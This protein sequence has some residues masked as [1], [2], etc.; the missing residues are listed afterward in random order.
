LKAMTVFDHKDEPHDEELVQRL[1]KMALEIRKDVLLM[2]T[3]AGSGHPGGSLSAAEMIACLYFHHLRYDPENPQWEDRDRFVLSKGHVCP[4]LYSALSRAGFFPREALWTLRKIGSILQ[5]HP[6]MKKTPG[7][8]ASTGSLGQGLSIGVGMALAGRIDRKSYRVYV[9]LGDGELDEGQVWEA[10]MSAAHYRLDNLLAII[11]YNGLQLDGPVNQIM[12][13]EPIVEKWKAFGWHVIEIDGHNVR[14]I[15]DALDFAER[16]KGKPTAIIAHT[17][18]G[19]GISFM[20][21]KVEFHG[22]PL[23]EE[24]LKLALKELELQEKLLSIE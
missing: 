8:E 15:L 5:G 13:I 22:K 2:T 23:T 14:Q 7:V 10:A 21:G 1:R 24:Q 18:K 11:D 20:E 6:D 4:A 16:V 19:K 3:K 9:L 12:S 17:I